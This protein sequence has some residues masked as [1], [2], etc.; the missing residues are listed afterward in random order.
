MPKQKTNQGPCSIY[1][2]NK[3]S[4]RFKSLTDNAFAKN[5]LRKNYQN[6]IS[7]DNISLDNII[8]N[9]NPV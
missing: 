4:I 6:N 9:N 3:E 7:L 8:E 5:N 1:N 2:Y